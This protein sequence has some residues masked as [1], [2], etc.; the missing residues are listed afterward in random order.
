MRRHLCRL[1]PPCA[2]RIKRRITLRHRG[3]VLSEKVPIVVHVLR[4][5]A[6]CIALRVAGCRRWPI[7]EPNGHLVAALRLDCNRRWI[8]NLPVAWLSEIAK[9]FD[10]KT[11]FRLENSWIL[12]KLCERNALM[13]LLNR[14]CL[15]V[16]VAHSTRTNCLLDT[17]ARHGI[18]G[19]QA[20]HGALARIFDSILQGWIDLVH[21]R[22]IRCRHPKSF[23]WITDRAAVARDALLAT[24][25]EAPLARLCSIADDL[26]LGWHRETNARCHGRPANPSAARS[27]PL[28][29]V[30]QIVAHVLGAY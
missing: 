21:A 18:I 25:L 28:G 23:D 4:Y 15:D 3:K 19:K 24:R 11:V 17:R 2:C 13:I 6:L 22:S 16:G 12:G 29:R 26:V 9:H 8:E 20:T 7:V 27:V 30:V 14:L 10:R 5:D 1:V